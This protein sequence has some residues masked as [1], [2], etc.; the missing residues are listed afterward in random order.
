MDP[1]IITFIGLLVFTPQAPPSPPMK[2]VLGQ[3]PGLQSHASIIAYD[4]KTKVASNWLPAGT[5]T[6]KNG[7][8]YEYVSVTDQN[9]SF[10]GPQN[11]FKNNLGPMPH[12][13]CCCQVM[14]DLRPEYKD[15]DQDPL[16]KP[17]AF[18]M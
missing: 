4:I 18:F 8:I 16:S 9:V 5:F 13:S 17:S 3:V 11:P 2:V 14:E 10:A 1:T 12:L 7:I 15:L 6:L